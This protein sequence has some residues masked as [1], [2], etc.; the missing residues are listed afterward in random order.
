MDLD[1]KLKEFEREILA[2]KTA[3]L[4]PAYLNTFEYK[5]EYPAMTYNAGQIYTWTIY[6]KNVGDTNAPLTYSSYISSD[7]A[8]LPYN[9]ATNSQ[10]FEYTSLGETLY[11]TTTITFK[12]SRPIDRVV[13]NF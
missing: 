4:L 2:L 12:S 3:Q 1:K 10:V 5:A 8:L 11:V 7:Y 6:Y 9:S 13:R